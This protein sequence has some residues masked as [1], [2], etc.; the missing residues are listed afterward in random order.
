MRCGHRSVS[1]IYANKNEIC[2]RP[3]FIYDRDKEAEAKL[4]LIKFF[5]IIFSEKFR[6][7]VIEQTIRVMVSNE[8]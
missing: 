6:C 2:E 5:C 1:Y 7:D 3:I 4:S 8:F